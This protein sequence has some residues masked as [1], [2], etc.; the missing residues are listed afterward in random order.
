MIVTERVDDTKEEQ[1]Q[2]DEDITEKKSNEEEQTT[3]YVAED[4]AEIHTTSYIDQHDKVQTSDAEVKQEIENDE[5]F[6]PQVEDQAIAESSKMKL[7]KEEVQ[8][9][10]PSAGFVQHDTDKILQ[11][12]LLELDQSEV[13]DYVMQSC[14]P[15]IEFD[16]K[17]IIAQVRPKWC[18]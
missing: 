3:Q 16:R 13:I 11:Q 6:G 4:T 10:S 2:L 17:S 15:E 9:R 5:N 18:K 1:I 8:T 7:P 12:E 14:I